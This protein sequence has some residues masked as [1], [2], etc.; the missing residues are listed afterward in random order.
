MNVK[1]LKDATNLPGAEKESGR[2]EKVRAKVTGERGSGDY[3]KE[4]TNEKF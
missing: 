1:L 4:K 3:S 2:E